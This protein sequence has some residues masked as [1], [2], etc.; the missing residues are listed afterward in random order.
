MGDDLAFLEVISI[1]SLVIG[2]VLAFFEPNVEKTKVPGFVHSGRIMG[3]KS[4]SVLAINE[5]KLSGKVYFA[6]E[7]FLAFVVACLGV[8]L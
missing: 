7:S 8:H 1:H 3:E 4:H 6:F 2:L 5:V